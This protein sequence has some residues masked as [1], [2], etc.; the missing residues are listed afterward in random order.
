M[1]MQEY[2]VAEA[3]N[4]SVPGN[5]AFPN[6]I[7]AKKGDCLSYD[8][9]NLKF[10][11][12]VAVTQSLGSCINFGWLVPAN[13]SFKVSG[14]VSPSVQSHV[15]SPITEA[16]PV[17]S[18]VASASSDNNSKLLYSQST[19]S[20]R[21][22]NI[23]ENDSLNVSQVSKPNDAGVQAVNSTIPKTA[24]ERL[25]VIEDDG[26]EIVKAVSDKSQIVNMQKD[27]EEVR[28]LGRNV[29]AKVK[30]VMDQGS[31]MTEIVSATRTVANFR[32]E[33]TSST[34]R[35]EEAMDRAIYKNIQSSTG[36]EPD[37]DV[38][39]TML[40]DKI[41]VAKQPAALHGNIQSSDPMV[42]IANSKTKA[43]FAEELRIRKEQKKLQKDQGLS[44]INTGDTESSVPP[45]PPSPPSPPP[46]PSAPEEKKVNGFTY[47]QMKGAGWTDNQLLNSEYKDLVPVPDYE[48][49][50]D[51]PKK[52]EK[53]SKTAKVK[54]IH[55]EKENKAVEVSTGTIKT[56]KVKKISNEK[57]KKVAE[58][59]TVSVTCPV[60]IG[61][62]TAEE[63][64]FYPEGWDN[65]SFEEKI[66]YPKTITDK[67][68][69]EAFRASKKAHWKVK[70][71]AAEQLKSLV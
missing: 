59:P 23:E 14:Q 20:T 53:K 7:P 12:I 49:V 18:E 16:S 58:E 68:I 3:F 29:S 24:R 25:N 41:D 28:S 10:G 19:S 51:E 64:G 40:N 38:D 6:G 42:D 66:A 45:S 55:K 56:A 4:I 32:D 52:C 67:F 39:F 9:F 63:L 27:P 57:E 15:S 48:P 46:P 33:V 70:Q 11:T 50:F 31:E 26:V 44:T 47:S 54:N 5:G 43:D 60:K 35:T 21:G 17:V 71:S 62:N 13:N 8:G 30:T 34:P 37:N 65:F 69:L 36:V 22:L 2:I 61:M 1:S